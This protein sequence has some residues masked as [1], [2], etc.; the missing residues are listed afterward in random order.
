MRPESL[1]RAALVFL[2]VGAACKAGDSVLPDTVVD[3][4]KLSVTVLDMH[5]I[6]LRWTSLQDASNYTIERRANYQGEFLPLDWNGSRAQ[7]SYFDRNLSPGTTYGYRLKAYD[8]FGKLI[9]VSTVSAGRTP[10]EPGV[11]LQTVSQGDVESV[12]PDGYRIT[13]THGGVSNSFP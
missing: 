7:T 1:C 3:P 6:L 13:F 12:D 4:G 5:N 8:A 10:P 2:L 11:L 9:A